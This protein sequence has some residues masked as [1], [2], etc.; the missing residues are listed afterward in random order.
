MTAGDEE[1][2]VDAAAG[3]LVRPYTVTAGRTRPTVRLD[4]LSL[5]V[6]TGRRP[7]EM[8]PEHA[9]ALAC[10]RAP[11]SVAEVAAHLRLPVTITKVLLA[12]LLDCRAMTTQARHTA[13]DPTDRALL[14]KLLDGLQRA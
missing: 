10:C 8:A 13:A 11:T 4:L 5:V 12:D 2:W 7:R 3:P 6:A 9:E 14:E 1:V